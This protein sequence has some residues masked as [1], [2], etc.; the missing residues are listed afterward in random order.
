[1]GKILRMTRNIKALAITLCL[2]AA[3]LFALNAAVDAGQRRG[4]GSFGGGRSGGSFGGGRSSSSFGGGR[5]GGSFSGGGGSFGSGR[6]S[7]S[8]GGSRSYSNSG[9]S[10]SSSFGGGR[11]TSGSGSFGRSGSFGSSSF[12]SSRSVNYN[13]RS[14]TTSSTPYYYGGRPY[15]AVYVGGWGDYWYHPVWY[16]WTPFHPAFYYSGPQYINDPNGGYYVS[17]GFN[18]FHFLI[19]AA[20]FIFVIWLIARL[21]GFGGRKRL[22]YTNY[23]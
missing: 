19:G 12:T 13:G 1:M 6:S 9:R 15:H 18:F 2:V 14:Y 21:F 22:K 11:S 23:S 20:F 16:Y 3:L 7:S 17:G 4:G 10:N 5:S 8:F